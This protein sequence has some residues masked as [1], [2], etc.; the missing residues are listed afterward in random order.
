MH[1]DTVSKTLFRKELQH[2]HSDRIDH[3]QNASATVKTDISTCIAVRGRE[4]VALY[5]SSEYGTHG[6][7]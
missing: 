7:W 5:S 4:I 2:V 6:L 3:E 1:H